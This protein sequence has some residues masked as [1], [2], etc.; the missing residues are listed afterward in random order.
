VSRAGSPRRAFAWVQPDVTH[1][2]GI[3]DMPQ[4]CDA[5][6]SFRLP[7]A[8]HTGDLSQV[9]VRLSWPIRPARRS[10]TSHG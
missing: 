8:P 7:V 3:N 4:V 9:H 6:Q 1:M 10:S 2:A 5:A